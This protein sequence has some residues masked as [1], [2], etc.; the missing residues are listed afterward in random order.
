MKSFLAKFGPGDIVYAIDGYMDKLKVVE[1]EVVGII[2]TEDEIVYGFGSPTWDS[3]FDE[4]AY[5]EDLYETEEEAMKAMAK[6]IERYLIEKEWK[7]RE[8]GKYKRYHKEDTI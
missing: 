2:F 3:E 6:K 8:F 5:Q 4:V 1:K 7:D